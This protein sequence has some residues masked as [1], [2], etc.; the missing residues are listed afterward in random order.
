MEAP[1]KDEVLPPLQPIADT[2]EIRTA[3]RIHAGLEVA[4]APRQ[5]TVVPCDAEK[6]EG[7]LL[8]FA[9]AVAR[10]ALAPIPVPDPR[11][12]FKVIVDGKRQ[13]SF[14]PPERRERTAVTTLPRRTFEPP[15]HPGRPHQPRMGARTGTVVGRAAPPALAAQPS[16]RVRQL[17]QSGNTPN[18]P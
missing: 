8:P 16:P 3:M 10:I 12:L 13:F 5:V 7:A 18:P 17:S 6:R 15:A 11:E 4:T 14:V 1:G 2:D 9:I